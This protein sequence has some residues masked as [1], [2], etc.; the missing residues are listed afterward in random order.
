MKTT[1]LLEAYAKK[2][3]KEEGRFW[4]RHGANFTKH[5]S[6]LIHFNVGANKKDAF[7]HVLPRLAPHWNLKKSIS[8]TK[9][10]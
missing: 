10:T 7:Q 6:A 9:G 3:L 4:R 1:D 8:T 2:T 5:R